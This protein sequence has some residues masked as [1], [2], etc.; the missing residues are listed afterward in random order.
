MESQTLT[1]GKGVHQL[2]CRL[3][4]L[5]HFISCFIDQLKPFFTTQ[6]GAKQT[7]WSM[8]C[9]K[10]FMAIKKYLTEPLILA[11]PKVGDTLYLYIEFMMSQ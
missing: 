11:S 7:G 8:E 5:R 3:V 4:A 9:D 10:A 6:K 2:T 1:S